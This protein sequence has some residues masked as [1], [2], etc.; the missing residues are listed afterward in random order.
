MNPAQPKPSDLK[1]NEAA[2]AI[3][4]LYKTITTIS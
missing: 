3:S 2:C 4:N 1:Q